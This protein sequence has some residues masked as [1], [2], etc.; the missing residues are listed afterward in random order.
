MIE[1]QRLA[2]DET[3]VELSAAED[4]LAPRRRR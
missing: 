1:P 3:S 2:G 4:A